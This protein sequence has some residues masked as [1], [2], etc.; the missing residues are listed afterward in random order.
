MNTLEVFGVSSEQVASYIQRPEVD[1][2]FL[3]AL[4]TDKQIV[5]YGASKQGKTALVSRY[6]PYAKNM[7]VSLTPRTN[8]IDIYQSVL[9]QSGVSIK[10]AESQSSQTES[11]IGVAAR[12]KALIP[13]FG[14][15]EAETTGQTTAGSG[16]QIVGPSGFSVGRKGSYRVNGTPDNAGLRSVETY[17]YL[18]A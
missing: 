18:E 5:V 12:F 6:L 16:K 3:S 17:P 2:K 7:V 13:L 15:G 10:T 1:D 9:R 4:K 14:S 11:I 8:I